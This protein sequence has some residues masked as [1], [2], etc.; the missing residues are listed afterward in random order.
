MSFNTDYYWK[1]IV[2]DPNGGVASSDLWYFETR[3]TFA[4]VG[5]PVWS[6]PLGRE[7][8]SP[9]IDSENHIYVSTSNGYLYAFNI[10]GNV[11]WTF[12]LRQ[13]T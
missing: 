13:T 5:T 6:Y 12:N 4:V 3:N 8:T 9:A 11:L 10:D 2:K 1:V 7:F